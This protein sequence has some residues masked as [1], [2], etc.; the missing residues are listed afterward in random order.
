MNVMTATDQALD[1]AL[2]EACKTFGVPDVHVEQR[3]AIRCLLQGRAVFASFP[4][5]YG[6][7]LILPLVAK[8]VSPSVYP[9]RPIVVVVSPLKS[10][11]RE[12]VMQVMS[13]QGK[14]LRA[15]QVDW[16]E[17]DDKNGDCSVFFGTPEALL[18]TDEWRSSLQTWPLK[19][20]LIA[21]AV[22]EVHTVTLSLSGEIC[23][24]SVFLASCCVTVCLLWYAGVHQTGPRNHFELGAANC[25]HRR[26][27]Y[28]WLL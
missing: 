22:D 13:L 1:E 17:Q 27:A 10:L 4:T 6:K 23:Y 5:G 12:S 24:N 3:L 2:L 11:M 28:L 18:R 7:S 16:C 19:D 26:G 20:R 8:M 21:I 14:G 15:F 9:D 25:G